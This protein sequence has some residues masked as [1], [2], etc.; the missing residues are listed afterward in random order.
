MSDNNVALLDRFWE[1]IA[2]DDLNDD[3]WEAL[4]DGCGRCC[5]QKLED[6]D[7]GAVHTTD[8]ACSLLNTDT[9]RCNNYPKRQ[10]LVP[11]CLNV[12]PLNEDKLRWLPLS[13][14]YKRLAE[15]RSL[16]DWH[17]L[18]SGDQQSVHLA[19]IGMAGRCISEEQVPLHEWP[20]RLLD[21]SDSE[22]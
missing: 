13:C 1:N 14:A 2:L 19:G 4:C 3:E 17:P 18:I 9:C 8:I 22:A 10:T 20:R 7:T 5:L 21:W 12:R 11:D 6:E 15:G 16:A